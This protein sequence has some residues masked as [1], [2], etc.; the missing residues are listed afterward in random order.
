LENIS[1]SDLVGWAFGCASLIYAW[2]MNREAKRLKDIARLE[3]WNLYQSANVACGK[4][5]TV[6]KMYKSTEKEK[7]DLDVLEELAKADAC[8][9]ETYR[10]TIRHIQMVEPK[11]DIPAIDYWVESKKIP[12]HQ[13]EDFR[14]I[15]VDRELGVRSKQLTSQVSGMSKDGAPS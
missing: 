4:V 12:H 7:V 5:Q 13:W 6:L 15:V 1:L 2:Y 9:L 11:F 3:A 14:K 8:S 10:S